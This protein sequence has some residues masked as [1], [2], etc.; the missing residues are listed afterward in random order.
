MMLDDNDPRVVWSADLILPI[1]GESV[2][3][4]VREPNAKR[5]EKRL[6]ESNMFRIHQENGGTF[7]DFTWYIK[8]VVGSGKIQPHAGY[9]LGNE[10]LI[11]WLCGFPDIRD[12]APFSLH[13]RLTHDFDASRSGTQPISS[14]APRTVLLSIAYNAKEELLPSIQAIANNGIVL[15]AT[16]GTHKFLNE[17][18]VKTV[19][20]HKISEP[21]ENLIWLIYCKKC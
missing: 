19:L 2:G 18:G 21:E 10:R 13:A 12:C 20:V 9:G 11:Q 15:Y 14:P 5:L 16:S 17:H 1:A 6:L 8:D 7:D 4:A 3:S